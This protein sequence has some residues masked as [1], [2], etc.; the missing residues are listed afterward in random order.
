MCLLPKK[1]LGTGLSTR[2][3]LLRHPSK[4]SPAL[5]IQVAFSNVGA[6]L[7]FVLKGPHP[8]LG[9][10]SAMRYTILKGTVDHIRALFSNQGAIPSN[11]GPFVAEDAP[12][13]HGV[14]QCCSYSLT[15]SHSV[16]LFACFS[17]TL[18]SSS[19]SSPPHP[20][21]PYQ[22]FYLPYSRSLFCS[23]PLC[24]PALVVFL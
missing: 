11:P 5:L 13:C 8:G 18:S 16:F 2:A 9:P 4:G 22:L 10:A 24:F 3:F 20:T 14:L 19:P 6:V 21:S 23:R 15:P 12:F 7:P 1:M 17:H